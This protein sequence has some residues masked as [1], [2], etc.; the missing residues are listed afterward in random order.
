MEACLCAV[1]SWVQ[2][3]LG[4]EIEPGG[5]EGGVLVGHGFLE[6][7]LGLA[8]ERIAPDF[9][10]HAAPLTGSGSDAMRGRDTLKQ[11]IGGI[12]ASLPDLRF[13]IEVG[14]IAN[15]GFFSV[16]WRVEGTYAGGFP[17]ASEGAVGRPI[18]FTGT[19]TLRIDAGTL[20]EYWANSDTLLVVQQLGMIPGGEG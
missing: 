20:A 6:G 9:L 12:R 17:G 15:Q 5:R 8:D 18:K 1:V 3:G 10:V 14:P 16:R 19:D 11:W 4:I 2:P 13:S 7:D